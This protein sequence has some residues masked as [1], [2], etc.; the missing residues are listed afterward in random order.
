MHSQMPK[1][2]KKEQGRLIAKYMSLPDGTDFDK[3]IAENA[4]E[5]FLKYLEYKDKRYRRLLAIGIIE[6]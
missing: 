2:L 4:S 3:F 5:T 1:V 6:N